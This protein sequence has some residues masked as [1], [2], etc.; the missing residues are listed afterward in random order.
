VQT[1]PP[2]GP[3]RPRLVVPDAAHQL[4]APGRSPAAS[5]LVQPLL[6]AAGKARAN[7]WRLRTAALWLGDNWPGLAA[8]AIA[9]AVTAGLFWLLAWLLAT[10]ADTSTDL[11][12]W[13]RHSPVLATITGPVR[14]YLDTN[15]AGLPASGHDLWIGWLTCCGLLYIAALTGSRYGRA[16]WAAFGALSAAAAYAGAPHGAG[17][18]AAGVTATA[19]LVLS[20]PA[21]ARTAVPGRPARRTARRTEA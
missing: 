13:L 17:S 18:L 16:G 6:T 21:Y 1:P 2:T 20:L 7:R 10:A 12:G 8:W 4:L 5:P 14:S 11:L 15:S 19:W 9:A 3:G